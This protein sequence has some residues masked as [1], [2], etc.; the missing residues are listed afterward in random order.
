MNF[1]GRP[2]TMGAP[3]DGMADPIDVERVAHCL[4]LTSLFLWR[5]WMC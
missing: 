4:L 1:L 5:N 3:I 2:L